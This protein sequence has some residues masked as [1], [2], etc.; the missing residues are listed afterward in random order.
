MKAAVA[1]CLGL[2][3][4]LFTGHIAAGASTSVGYEF[5]FEIPYTFT[6][7][8]TLLV[9]DLIDGGVSDSQVTISR[10]QTDEGLS[11]FDSAGGFTPEGPD[12]FTLSDSDFFNEAR[13]VLP[14]LHRF[15]FRLFAEGGS[16][17]PEH[18][19]DQF[20]LF[21]TDAKIGFQLPRFSTTDPTGSNAL[22]TMSWRG[23]TMGSPEVH[24]YLDGTSDWSVTAVPEPSAWSLMVLGAGLLMAR[25]GRRR[26]TGTSPGT[27]RFAGGERA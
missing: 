5:S 27:G 6:F 17:A 3:L 16:V 14:A 23:S 15:S 21:V 25:Q 2:G 4:A 9:F 7:E 8:S 24:S 19:P 18:V 1:K 20:T 12:R 10:L 22:M 13:F 11:L 26:T